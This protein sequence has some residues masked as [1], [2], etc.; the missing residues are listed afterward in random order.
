MLKNCFHTYW[1]F[2]FDFTRKNGK[3]I[4]THKCFQSTLFDRNKFD[5]FRLPKILFEMR[6][7]S[8]QMRHAVSQRSHAMSTANNIDSRSWLV[9][10][11]V[12]LCINIADSSIF[13]LCV[14]KRRRLCESTIRSLLRYLA[15][16]YQTYPGYR[17]IYHVSANCGWSWLFHMIW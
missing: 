6:K 7:V 12:S 13:N 8:Q 15:Q 4:K 16:L 10:I 17:K 11:S 14:F 9:H 3:E 2:K 1:T 5:I